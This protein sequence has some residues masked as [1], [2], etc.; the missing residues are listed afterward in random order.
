MIE[1]GTWWKYTG[2]A[3]CR[4]KNWRGY[5]KRMRIGF[6]T[7]QWPGVRLGGIGAYTVHTAR[8]LAR[9]GWEVHVFTFTL[10]PE[11]RAGLGWELPGVV[12]H[13]VAAMAEAV[14]RGEMSAEMGM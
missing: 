13:E 4:G 11:M 3:M 6:L 7:H 5:N 1:G 10:P 9:V 12:V 2:W 14:E 8:A